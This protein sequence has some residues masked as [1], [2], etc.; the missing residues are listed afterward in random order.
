MLQQT[1]K[2]RQGDILF[3]IYDHIYSV[4]QICSVSQNGELK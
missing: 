3:W 1:N 4:I 2:Y